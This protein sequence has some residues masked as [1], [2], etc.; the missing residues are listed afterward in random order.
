MKK[1][2]FTLIEIIIVVTIISLFSGGTIAYYNQSVNKK[3]L[4]SAVQKLDD[5]LHL[6][7]KKA[8]AGDIYTTCSNFTGYQVRFNPTGYTTYFC[9]DNNCSNST[10]ISTYKLESP[11]T[12]SSSNNTIYFKPLTGDINSSVNITVKITNPTTDK[13]SLFTIEPSGLMT[14]ASICTP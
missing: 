14:L 13:C 9:C 3:K 11:L 4:D 5:V 10:Q 8:M 1:K 12:L 2:A 6:M 7:Q